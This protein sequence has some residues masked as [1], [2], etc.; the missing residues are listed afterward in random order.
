MPLLIRRGCGELLF[1][2]DLRLFRHFDH[3]HRPDDDQR[4]DDDASVDQFISELG[5]QEDR[6][7]RIY[8][9]IG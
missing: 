8:I 6:Y 7:N 4:S 2:N 1:E 9:G 5:A 3:D